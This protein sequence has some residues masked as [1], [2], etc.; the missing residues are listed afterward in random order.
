MQNPI[1]STILVK[2]GTGTIPYQVGS[3]PLATGDAKVIFYAEINSNGAMVSASIVATW[4]D[5]QE[6]AWMLQFVYADYS[7]TGV[8]PGTPPNPAVVGAL[9]VAAT[10]TGSDGSVSSWS[11]NPQ[12]IGDFIEWE[13]IPTGWIGDWSAMIF[14]GNVPSTADGGL[15]LIIS[16]SQLSWDVEA[17][18]QLS[19]PL[20][21][22]FS[23]FLQLG[24]GNIEFSI[25]N[26]ISGNGQC[27]VTF[28]AMGYGLTFTGF[29]IFS[30]K[31]SSTGDTWEFNFGAQTLFAPPGSLEIPCQLTVTQ[32][33]QNGNQI[34][35]WSGGTASVVLS[36]IPYGLVGQWSLHGSGS[37]LLGSM[38]DLLTLSSAIVTFHVTAAEVLQN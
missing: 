5:T 32:S 26:R 22:P 2:N 18:N 7:D 23:I 12:A 29:P 33:D 13:A 20:P 3:L 4:N 34:E 25:V 11:T 37:N 6:N 30:W 27:A 10:Q 28:I 35:Y 21:T 24:S 15:T 19:Q 16:V 9:L 14:A 17:L 36:A 1:Q 31:D 8:T 38:G